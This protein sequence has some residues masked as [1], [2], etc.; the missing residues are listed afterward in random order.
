M[1]IDGAKQQWAID[2]HKGKGDTPTKSDLYGPEL[3][4]KNEPIC[5]IRG[6]YRIGSVGQK[7]RCE[8]FASRGHSL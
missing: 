8:L 1:Q 5:P 2:N 7:P 4:L 6:R 3:Y